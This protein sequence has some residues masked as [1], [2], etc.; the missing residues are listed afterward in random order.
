MYAERMN[1][2][3]PIFENMYEPDPSKRHRTTINLPLTLLEEAERELGSAS[4][5]ETVTTALREFVAARRRARL[6]ALD[7]PDLTLESVEELRRPR[8]DVPPASND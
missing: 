3:M 6:L 1:I 8:F 5:T 2:Y 4:A 7:L